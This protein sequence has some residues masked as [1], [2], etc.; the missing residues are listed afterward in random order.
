MQGSDSITFELS[1]KL[2][3]KIVDILSLVSENALTLPPRQMLYQGNLSNLSRHVSHSIIVL[4]VN[5][6]RFRRIYIEIL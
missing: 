5:L 6:V 3:I 4:S 2:I 1:A